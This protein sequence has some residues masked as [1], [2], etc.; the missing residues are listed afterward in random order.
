MALP[1][2][3]IAAAAGLALHN[4]AK[5]ENEKAEKITKDAENLYR[6]YYSDLQYAEQC[7]KKT[8]EKLEN[9]KNTIR[10]HSMKY[11]FEVA[12]WIDIRSFRETKAVKELDVFKS[13][14]FKSIPLESMSNDNLPAVFVG[15]LGGGAAFATN[16][17]LGG[18]AAVAAGGLLGGVAPVGIAA[19]PMLMPL[20][21][22]VAPVAFAATVAESMKAFT[23]LENAN[24]YYKQAKRASEQMEQM[25]NRCNGIIKA[26]NMINVNLLKWD[27]LFCKCL[28][29][30]DL[31]VLKKRTYDGRK[32]KLSDFSEQEINTIAVTYA[33]ACLIE[34]I[35][36][37]SFVSKQ[38]EDIEKSLREC[39]NAFLSYEQKVK[40]LRME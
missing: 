2:F 36:N 28:E 12:S 40:R 23:N 11:F 34:E 22:F 7:A 16:E 6:V 18:S 5:N 10:E 20:A 27:K 13:E 33:I 39:Q 25:K 8:L 19:N 26:A 3:V 1:L 31:I 35:L 38:I 21:Q 9:S 32:L 37:K 17:I 30:T 4:D 24:E 15:V 29:E 14:F